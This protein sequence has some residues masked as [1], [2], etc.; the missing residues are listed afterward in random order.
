M[1]SD[2]LSFPSDEIEKVYSLTLPL[3]EC[4]C[5]RWSREMHNREKDPESEVDIL[6]KC[7]PISMGVYILERNLA[8]RVKP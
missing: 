7:W 3:W 4:L 6:L 5:H 1:T 2:S 8:H